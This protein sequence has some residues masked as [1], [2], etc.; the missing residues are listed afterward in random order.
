MTQY[1]CPKKGSAAYSIQQALTEVDCLFPGLLP[2]RCPLELSL[3]TL[4]ELPIFSSGGLKEAT[5]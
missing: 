5:E 3:H 1:F 2:S 4:Q